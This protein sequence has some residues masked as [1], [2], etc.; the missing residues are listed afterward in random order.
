MRSCLFEMFGI[1]LFYHKTMIFFFF[2]ELHEAMI[3][4]PQFI[5]TYLSG[6]DIE[7]MIFHDLLNFLGHVIYELFN[8]K[9]L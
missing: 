9:S 6:H 1:H 2:G 3:L 7:N 5:E 8:N 4:K